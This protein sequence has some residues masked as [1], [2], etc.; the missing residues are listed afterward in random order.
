MPF[1]AGSNLCCASSAC[2]LLDTSSGSSKVWD[3]IPHVTQISTNEQANNPTLV[4]S[5]SEGQEIPACGSVSTTGNL[6]IACHDGTAPGLLCINNNYR[7][8]WSEDCDNIWDGD[9]AVPDNDAGLHFEALVKI[10]SVPI[11]YNIA[12]NAPLVYNY[13]FRVVTWVTKPTCQTAEL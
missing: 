13:G 1:S 11:D 5:D 8:R 4:T 3:K 6:A 9:S 2:V 7:L 12:G 10:T